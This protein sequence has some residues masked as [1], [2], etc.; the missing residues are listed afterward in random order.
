MVLVNSV[1]R[2]VSVEFLFAV[3]GLSGKGKGQ[4]GRGCLGVCWPGV[5]CVCEF[6]LQSLSAHVINTIPI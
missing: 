5:C 1:R 6:A 3:V 4:C 2:R